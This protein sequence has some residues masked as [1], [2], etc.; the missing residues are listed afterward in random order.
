MWIRECMRG[1]QVMASPAQKPTEHGSGAT[2]VADERE[3]YG[4][5]KGESLSAWS[6]TL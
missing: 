1:G 3:G 4:S 2:A 5:R 6:A